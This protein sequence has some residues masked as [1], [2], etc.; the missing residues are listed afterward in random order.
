M[1]SKADIGSLAEALRRKADITDLNEIRQLATT[2]ASNANMKQTSQRL[3][4]V[5]FELRKKAD[6]AALENIHEQIQQ[7]SAAVHRVQD[8]EP[9]ASDTA[10]DRISTYVSPI[11]HSL[12]M[13]KEDVAT[14]KRE[15]AHKP[16]EHERL[17]IKGRWVSFL[18]LFSN[19]SQAQLVGR[20]GRPES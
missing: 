3:D 6:S 1:D 2:N 18:R 4:R 13:L 19:V 12:E 10:A 5:D 9:I 11:Q 7:L 15:L 16:T 14:V 8:S 20:S 17:H